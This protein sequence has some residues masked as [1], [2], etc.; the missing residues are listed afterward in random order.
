MFEHDFAQF[1]LYVTNKGLVPIIV[2]R[3]IDQYNVKSV[4]EQVKISKKENGEITFDKECSE[5]KFICE[6][7]FTK[8]II[9]YAESLK[10]DKSLGY[11]LTEYVCSKIQILSKEDYFISEKSRLLDN[12][13]ELRIFNNSKAVVYKNGFATEYE[14]LY[15][16]ADAVIKSYNERKIS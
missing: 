13:A 5:I 10:N 14:G 8:A 11:P 2:N 3:L 12:D 16:E 7:I 15:D 6:P 9:E 1:S 4:T